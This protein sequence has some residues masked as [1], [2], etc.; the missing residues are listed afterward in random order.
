MER[1]P[2]PDYLRIPVAGYLAGHYGQETSESIEA[3]ALGLESSF[4]H[5]T[6]IKR[7]GGWLSRKKHFKSLTIRLEDDEFHLE[8][9]GTPPRF[10]TTKRHVVRGI[11]LSNDPLNMADW[12]N[13]L[14]AAFETLAANNAEAREALRKWVS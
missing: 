4:P 10:T 6:T 14:A 8:A 11:V 13:Q 1:E 5:L 2:T 9:T 7:E 3:L 12:L